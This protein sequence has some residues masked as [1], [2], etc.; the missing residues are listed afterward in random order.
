MDN[1]K[2]LIELCRFCESSET[3]AFLFDMLTL[4]NPRDVCFQTVLKVDLGAPRQQP[5]S[6]CGV[7][8]RITSV[9]LLLLDVPYTGLFAHK[10]LYASDE[11]V[12]AYC[13]PPSDVKNFTFTIA[14]S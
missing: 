10:A 3:V 7:R 9:S 8:Q 2:Q 12:D 14:F 6:L 11:G 1:V 5:L 13:V 4:Q